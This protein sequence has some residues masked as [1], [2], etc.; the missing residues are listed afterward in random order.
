M[1][2]RSTVF[3]VALILISGT[4]MFLIKYEAITLEDRRDS[5]TRT[6][7]AHREAVVVLRAE[8]SYRNRPQR[9]ERLV[10]DRLDHEPTDVSQIV[11]LDRIPIRSDPVDEYAGITQG[12]MTVTELDDRAGRSR[13]ATQ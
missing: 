9:I 3:W 4:A 2:R 12:N 11:Y 6:I 1:I 7:R 13:G 5:L 8:W 10:T